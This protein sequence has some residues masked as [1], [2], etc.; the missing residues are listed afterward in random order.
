MTKHKKMHLTVWLFV[1]KKKKKGLGPV[2]PQCTSA[3]DSGVREVNVSLERQIAQAA[4]RSPLQ[5]EERAPVV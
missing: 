5:N 4:A 3:V 2:F 1:K